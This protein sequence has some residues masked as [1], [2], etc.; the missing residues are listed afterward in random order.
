MT[1][2]TSKKN[3]VPV[4]EQSEKDKK[5][6][7]TEKSR[8]KTEAELSEEDKN[9]QDELDLCVERLSDPN[10]E[11][12]LNALNTLKDRIRTATSS[13]TSVPKPLKMLRQHWQKMVDSFNEYKDDQKFLNS[14]AWFMHAEVLS[15]LGMTIED[16]NDSS[17]ENKYFCL[18]YRLIAESFTGVKPEIVSS[19]IDV[20]M[21]AMTDEIKDSLKDKSEARKKALKGLGSWGHE[22][23]KRLSYDIINSWNELADSDEVGEAEK[24]N[25]KLVLNNLG[26][27]VGRNLKFLPR[28]KKFLRKFYHTLPHSPK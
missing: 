25:K 13:L 5:A 1:A 10:P 12:K 4:P 14:P 22:Y 28:H 19:L 20:N 27:W 2:S 18:K 23:V 11:I 21:E 3:E 8:P 16:D 17:G 24:A 26:F 9:L 6:Q 7:E 15:V